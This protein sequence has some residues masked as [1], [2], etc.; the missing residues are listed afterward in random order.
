M[1]PSQ[2]KDAQL[3]AK[4]RGRLPIIK[5][6]EYIGDKKPPQYLFTLIY[7]QRWIIGGCNKECAF[8][9]LI[10][11]IK[12]N[13]VSCINCYKPIGPDSSAKFA[14]DPQQD[15]YL[16][17]SSE[18]VDQ[19]IPTVLLKCEHV[20]SNNYISEDTSIHTQTYKCSE[21]DKNIMKK[22][23]KDC[24]THDYPIKEK[25]VFY[26]LQCD[27]KVLEADAKVY[28]YE[29]YNTSYLV[30]SAKCIDKIIHMI[31]SKNCKKC[32]FNGTLRCAKCKSRYCS[33]ECQAVD[34]PIHK[35]LCKSFN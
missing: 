27:E 6:P 32:G 30:C 24:P 28:K 13:A 17:C 25:N 2:L 4:L 10:P 20:E 12:D 16:C 19:F 26:C 23:C 3:S 31:T 22:A 11:Y 33:K 9:P 35:T 7:G 29:K 18:C 21:S 34:W 8:N 14:E 15:Q 1:N 5:C